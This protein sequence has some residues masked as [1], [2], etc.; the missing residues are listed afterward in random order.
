MEQRLKGPAVVTGKDLCWPPQA[1]LRREGP[2]WL[3]QIG[4]GRLYNPVED[5]GEGGSFEALLAVESGLNFK[6]RGRT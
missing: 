2:M 5:G 1:H 3:K 4:N 6:S